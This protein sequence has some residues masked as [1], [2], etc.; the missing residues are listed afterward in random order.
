M[1]NPGRSSR[2]RGSS[3]PL[4]LY[5]LTLASALPLGQVLAAAYPQPE[6][7]C[8]GIGWGCSL[9]G[10]D[11]AYF[12]LMVVGVPYALAL[13]FVLGLLSLLP[14]R[15]RGVQT[16]VAALGLAVPWGTVLVGLAYAQR[17]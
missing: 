5:L 6:G 11:A 15:W 8:S 2:G 16:A 9:Y 12:V 3:A 17:G 10:W 7:A 13:G 1:S 14:E 4:V